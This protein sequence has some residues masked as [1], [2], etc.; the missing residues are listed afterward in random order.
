MWMAG[1]KIW[2]VYIKNYGIEDLCNALGYGLAIWMN[3][4]EFRQ[5]IVSPV[6]KTVSWSHEEVVHKVKIVK[7]NTAEFIVWGMI[8]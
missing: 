6:Q 3:A 2:Q 7:R 5:S 1:K 8:T 4:A